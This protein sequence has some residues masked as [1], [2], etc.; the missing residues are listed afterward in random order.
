METTI[1]KATHSGVLPCG[2]IPCYVLEDGRRVLS[3]R[4]MQKAIGIE[5]TG[6]E[7]ALFCG[8]N[9]IEP[10]VTNDLSL[11]M[12]NP[13]VFKTQSGPIAHGYEATVLIDLCNAVLAA[14]R[15]GALR[16]NQLHIAR[17]CELLCLAGVP[18][19]G[20]WPGAWAWSL[21]L[22]PGRGAWPWPGPGLALAW[23]W[24]LALIQRAGGVLY[25]LLHTPLLALY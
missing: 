21:A 24:S 11:V 12:R 25:I 14:R 8:V 20:A 19:P 13:I 3:G 2:N 4:G 5:R 18:G 10:F 16:P 17:Q 6:Q 9:S 15:A 1:L 23:P 22:V 7:L